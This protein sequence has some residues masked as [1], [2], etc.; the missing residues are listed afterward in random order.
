MCD[1]ES[2]RNETITG[3]FPLAF[4]A[5]ISAIHAANGK[6]ITCDRDVRIIGI[7]KNLL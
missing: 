6:E 5:I 7:E 2:S 4:K 1:E 3:F